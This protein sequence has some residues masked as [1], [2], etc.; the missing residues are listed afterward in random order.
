MK[1]SLATHKD[2]FLD[3][4]AAMQDTFKC[5]LGA[6]TRYIQWEILMSWFLGWLRRANNKTFGG[7]CEAIPGFY[8]LTVLRN[9]T[10]F[11]QNSILKPK[12]D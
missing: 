5:Y 3:F 1:P 8:P 4:S 11:A 6:I 10:G 12:L 9:K 2:E 7:K